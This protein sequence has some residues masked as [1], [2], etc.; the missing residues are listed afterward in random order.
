MKSTILKSF[1]GVV[2]LLCL[3]LVAHAQVVIPIAGPGT[4]CKNSTTG[5]AVTASPGISYQW[6]ISS[7]TIGNLSPAFGPGTFVFWTT[8]GTVTIS[9]QGKDAGNAVVQTGSISVT[10]EPIPQPT[11]TTDY[12][13]GCQNF[14]DSTKGHEQGQ[15]QP[16]LFDGDG[17]PKVCE[18]SWV[19]Y[20]ANGAGSSS[21]AWTVS[22]GVIAG[23]PSSNTVLVHWGAIGMGN[24]SVT[25]TTSAGC[26]GTRNVC[27]EIISKPHARFGAM[28]DTLAKS[29]DVCL[30][31][32][33]LFVDHS[34]A[35]TS[36]TIVN[37]YW[38]FGDG[39]TFS[40]SV[41]TNPQHQYLNP[42]PYK[43]TLVVKNACNCTDTAVLDVNVMEDEGVKITCASVVCERARAS[44]TL[45]DAISC[46][47]YLWNVIG[48]TIT[49][50]MPYGPSIDV[51]WDNVDDDGFGYV[52]FD[53]SECPDVK[54]ASTT[55]IKIPVVKQK[56][57]IK[58]QVALCPNKEYKYT[59]PAWPG[60]FFNWSI[61]NPA[62]GTLTHSDQPNEIV[63]TTN[64]NY[65]SVVIHCDYN[66]PVSGCTGRA[67]IKVQ[68]FSP[69]NIVGGDVS[70][71]LNGASVNPYSLASGGTGDWTLIAPN[72]ATTT[73]AGVSSVSPTFTQVGVY[74]LGVSGN[75]CSPAPTQITV[76]GPPPAP[77]FI[78]GVD[79]VCLNGTYEFTAGNSLPGSIFDWTVVGGAIVGP[80]S[81]KT[82]SV[83]FTASSGPYQVIVHRALTQ[84][85]YCAG[86]GISKTLYTPVINLALTGLHTVCPNSVTQYSSG[87]VGAETYEWSINNSTYGSIDINSNNVINVTWNNQTTTILAY[88]TVK[89]KRCGTVKID[90]IQV[91]I[92]PVPALTLTAPDVCRGQSVTATLGSSVL[93]AGSLAWS[94]PDLTGPATTTAPGG[95]S[96]TYV[97]NDI[98]TGNLTKN[99]SVVLTNPNGCLGSY[100]YSTQVTVKPAPIALIS[101]AGPIGVCGSFSQTLTATLQSGAGQTDMLAWSSGGPS[102][103]GSI[104]GGFPCS[105][106]TVSTLGSY[107]VT[108]TN[109]ANGCSSNSNTV[110]IYNNCIPPTCTLSPQPTFNGLSSENC[111]HVHVQLNYG[112]SNYSSGPSFGYD[113]SATGV[114]TNSG[115]PGGAPA[116]IDADFPAAGSYNFKFTFDYLCT[117]G[118]HTPQVVDVPVVVPVVAGILYKLQCTNGSGYAI[119]MLDHSTIW[120]F[121][122][123]VSYQYSIDAGPYG[124]SGTSSPFISLSSGSHTISVHVHGIYNGSPVDCY[125]TRTVIVPLT[126]HAIFTAGPT[127]ACINQQAITLHNSSTNSSS[128]LWDFGD[129]AFNTIPGTGIN[130]LVKTYGTTGSYT[131]VLNAYDGYG[132]SDQATTS[133]I[134]Q[135]NNLNG[136]LTGPSTICEGATAT[137]MY[138]PTTGAPNS[139][140]WMNDLAPVFVT[141]TNSLTV[142]QGGNYWVH[143]SNAFGC[144]KNTDKISVTVTHVPDPVITGDDLQCV[145]NTFTLSGYAGADPGITYSWTCNGGYAGNTPS[146]VQSGLG[147]GTYNYVLTVTVNGCSKTSATFTV[148]V[149]APP[150]PPTISFN[151]MNCQ[152]YTLKLTA[153]P[154]APGTYNWSNAA[155]GNPITT[156]VGGPYKVWYTDLSGCTVSA[157]A[158]VPKDPA[159]YLWIF[160]TGCYTICPPTAIPNPIIP[161]AYWDDHM[162]PAPVM[163]SGT[164]S[165]PG[166]FYPTA[167]GWYGMTLDNGYCQVTIDT[168]DLTI[169]CHTD[170]QPCKELTGTMTMEYGGNCQVYPYFGLTNSS[171]APLP[172]TISSSVGTV[173]PPNNTGTLNPGFTSISV[174]WIP[175][176]GFVSGPVTFYVTVTLSN[177]TTCGLTF[178]VDV[179]CPSGCPVHRQA[180]IGAADGGILLTAAP[181][182]AHNAAVISYRFTGEMPSGPRTIDVYDV[183]GRRL[184]SHEAGL[185]QSGD[186]MLNTDD[187]AAGVYQVVMKEGGRAVAV[188]RLSITH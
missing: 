46:G 36:S 160:P 107:F 43:V 67:D 106:Y 146:L 56:G 125:A 117:S 58:G 103:S 64:N 65:G 105:I 133:I 90:T 116:T 86:P 145:G 16:P 177:G 155:S 66:T 138:G 150:P 109:S 85:P 176:A 18:D 75:F 136:V 139:F 170:P 93:T 121:V 78:T 38:D 22:G 69:D 156:Y 12:R 154:P 72:G 161:F 131:I 186:W 28:P 25:E 98:S 3:G 163:Q 37:W 31:Q 52:Q 143:A 169:N 159:G 2:W 30:K 49:S 44:Y 140:K 181:N 188:L 158:N 162:V 152:P 142:S 185:F 174:H 128:Y 111:G 164:N 14:P 34:F 68:V 175:P 82:V 172:Y 7:T 126:P 5:Y 122:T 184:A 40:S 97:F 71:C 74:S 53:A 141:A 130:P 123:G 127:T 180:Q 15:Q 149:N 20:T 96:N 79:T 35:S 134:V 51:V 50:A 91:H 95:Q 108:A 8:P 26:Q 102:C 114:V 187:F 48:G 76:L 60:T 21:F 101:P 179:K 63:L 88:L 11:I 115:A 29:V 144:Y 83:Q 62:M 147:A 112:G 55:T 41:S 151:V 61:S 47:K 70:V 165:I 99:I 171:G 94:I 157:V 182:P 104:I 42:G 45:Q 153:N 59:L 119:Q 137:L 33:V 1:F 84:S 57:M 135:P 73:Y 39:Q 6:T 54:C 129:G 173:A 178:T 183:T 4:V 120:P 87:Y 80:T 23:Y 118:Q 77:D 100:T 89:V 19:T 166:T 24:V 132:C 167:G 92:Q 10:V 17:C 124:G 13:V 110:T 32:W 168:M 113:A 9:V 81:G 27:I 148:V